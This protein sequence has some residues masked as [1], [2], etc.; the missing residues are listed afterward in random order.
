MTDAPEDLT[1]HILTVLNFC[2]IID[3]NDE[4]SGCSARYWSSYQRVGS[5]SRIG[6]S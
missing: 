3:L 4:G 5:L 1:N 2:D 6:E